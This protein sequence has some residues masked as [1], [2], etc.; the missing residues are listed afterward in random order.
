MYILKRLYIEN[1][2]LHPLITLLQY[3]NNE[4]SISFSISFDFVSHSSSRNLYGVI[5]IFDIIIL[6]EA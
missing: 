3:I 2:G 1:I 4:K 5:H 6:R